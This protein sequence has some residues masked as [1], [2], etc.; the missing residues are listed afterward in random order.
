MQNLGISLELDENKPRMEYILRE[1][2]NSEI[3]M[4]DVRKVYYT[5]KTQLIF[6][7]CLSKASSFNCDFVI[8]VEQ[9]MKKQW[10]IL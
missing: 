5:T 7:A 10:S 6:D 4:E 2:G 1:A 8:A 9:F 3:Q